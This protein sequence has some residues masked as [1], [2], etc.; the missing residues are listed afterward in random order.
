MKPDMNDIGSFWWIKTT[1][2]D[3]PEVVRIDYDRYR[4]VLIAWFTG[5]EISYP[6]DKFNEESWLGPVE[7]CK[8]LNSAAD[9]V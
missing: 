2:D 1:K 3:S 5:W 9:N 4:K 7:P 6:V 8:T